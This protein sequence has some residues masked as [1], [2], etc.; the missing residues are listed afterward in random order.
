[1]DA[2]RGAAGVSVASVWYD[3]TFGQLQADT[4]YHLTA[5][6]DGENLKTYKDGVLITNN[7]EPSGNADAE[8]ES[9]KFAKHAT[10]EIYFHGTIDDVRV[11]N[12]ALSENEIK[13]ICTGKE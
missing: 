10:G 11:Y 2:F 8:S 13:A 5:T 9:L 7:S 3:A 4:W 6:Y 1:M 12:Y